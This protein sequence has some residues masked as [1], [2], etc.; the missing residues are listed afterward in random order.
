M[1]DYSRLESI[2]SSETKGLMRTKDNRF[3]MLL[4]GRYVHSLYTCGREAARLVEHILPLERENTLVIF[5]GAGLGYHIDAL[6]KEGF[7]N[8]I[9]IERN[10]EIFSVFDKI[11]SPG[12]NSYV[13]SP[14]D[15]P[16]RLDTII[17]MSRH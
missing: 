5:L 16:S 7:K 6:E 9:I 4:H 3:T 10:R 13:I 8:L 17:T 1:I 12:D 14:D 15:E 11:Y 2:A